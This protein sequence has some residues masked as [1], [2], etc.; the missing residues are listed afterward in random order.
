MEST[1]CALI[2]ANDT[3]VDPGLR[4]LRAP[5]HDA[6][7]LADV[8]H[9]PAI[10]DFDVRTV[11]NQPAHEV[12][13][14]I[15]G[16]FAERSPDDLLLLHFSGHGVKDENGDLYFA[17]ADTDLTLLGATAVSAEFVN[18]L[19]TRTR[20]RRVVLFLDC[21]Y[22]GAFERGLS[23][24]GDTD[25][26]L[27][28]RLGGRGR[29]VITASTAMEYAF[30]GAELTDVSTSGPSVFTSAVVDAL[31]TGEADTDQDGL[32]GL[33][34]LYEYVYDKV[35]SVTP[36]QTPSKWTLGF[37]GE[38][39]LARRST[40][41]TTPVPLPDELADAVASPLSRVRSAAVEE[42]DSLL[43]G[44]HAGRA[45]AARLALEHLV[46]DDSRSVAA[47]ASAAL[48]RAPVVPPQ[49][50]SLSGPTTP[51][52]P[53][54]P[55]PPEP[56]GPD[57]PTIPA[58]PWQGRR[59]IAAAV[60]ALVLVVGGGTWFAVAGQGDTQGDTQGGGGGG[61]D[62]TGGA[63][64]AIPSSSIV[65]AVG[66]G[67]IVRGKLVQVDTRTKKVTTVG[68]IADARLP[69][70][71]PDRRSII[72][73]AGP[74]N[75]PVPRIVN[76]DG[77]NDRPFLT[78]ASKCSSSDRPA[79]SPE[80]DQVVIVC[81]QQDPATLLLLGADGTLIRQLPT[82]GVPQGSP[83]WVE[84]SSGER[85]VVFMHRD[86]AGGPIALW[87]T[88]AGQDASSAVPLTEGP[89]DT[90]PDGA[91]DKLLFLRQNDAGSAIGTA[92]VKTG[93]QVGK[94]ERPLTALGEIGSP[95]WSPDGD[96][97]AYLKDGALWVAAADGTGGHRIDVGG[98]SG[99][100]AWGSR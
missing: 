80:G 28:E 56:P 100:P 50:V 15:E 98:T 76:A 82:N 6:E 44:T 9:D 25:L 4:R 7:A 38:L 29:A 31:R 1:R 37:Q 81:R 23:T 61:G 18:R 14:A 83:T 91:T 33:E 58:R 16:F 73:L 66:E 35:R 77:S 90:H 68:D 86:G 71:S 12:D 40:P 51:P 24:R 97:I 84:T 27:G 92:W 62:A 19:M 46:S 3:F 67:E 10:G 95:T 69:T 96:S 43:R 11:L 72:Y 2:V 99:A 65:V 22:A 63:A 5:T 48:A 39:Y 8:L 94:G 45:L 60:A 57:E 53:P 34:E 75:A 54:S 42:L 55:P 41:V 79:W 78:D 26:H 30:E 13:R 93:N 85:A 70:I 87:G 21:C 74:L 49:P 88:D 32:I 47:A 64:A 52:E 59:G 89:A 17:A 20:S 36:S